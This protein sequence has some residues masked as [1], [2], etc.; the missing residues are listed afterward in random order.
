[1]SAGT[2]AVFVPTAI[3]A[4]LL[5]SLVLGVS[6]VV[7]QLR[8]ERQ[9]R[10]SVAILGASTAAAALGG[11]V[12]SASRIGV[13]SRRLAVLVGL[14]VGGL[15]VYGLIGSFWNYWNPEDGFHDIAWVWA[16]SWLASFAF[17][18]AGLAALTIARAGRPLR[19][20][21]R[22]LVVKTR[23]GSAPM[24]RTAVAVAPGELGAEQI[25]GR[26]QDRCTDEQAGDDV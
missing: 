9:R 19:G 24:D 21:A 22:T 25:L 1:V 15:G 6:D 10:R 14:A 4:G 3:G 5:T 17:F 26:Q 12:D 8:S 13:R 7:G 20:P 23:L 16:L 11:S 18:G 2:L